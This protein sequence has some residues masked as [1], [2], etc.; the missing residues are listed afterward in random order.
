MRLEMIR[1]SLSDWMY[2]HRV[3]T[4]SLCSKCPVCFVYLNLCFLNCARV[5]LICNCL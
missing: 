3:C 2:S 4:E 5:D 1:Y